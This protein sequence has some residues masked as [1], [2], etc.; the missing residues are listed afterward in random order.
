MVNVQVLAK[1]IKVT[2]DNQEM[3]FQYSTVCN[4]GTSIFPDTHGIVNKTRKWI[5]GF[6]CSCH[7]HH[8]QY[9]SDITIIDT[10]CGRG[11]SFSSLV[12]QLS[13]LIMRKQTGSAMYIYTYCFE[14]NWLTYKEVCSLVLVQVAFLTSPYFTN[15]FDNSCWVWCNLHCIGA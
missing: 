8:H 2:I 14:T 5:S 3:F 12:I 13:K 15:W 7:S 11:A 4:I 9:L 1:Q 6:C 10:P